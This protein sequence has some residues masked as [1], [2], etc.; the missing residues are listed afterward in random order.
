LTVVLI[1]YYNECMTT[2]TTPPPKGYSTWLD[3]AVATMDTRS[4]LLEAYGLHSEE[5]V[6]GPLPS[7]DDIVDAARAELTALREADADRMGVKN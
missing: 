3:Y 5:E 1:E 2:Q 4:A 7:R 6:N